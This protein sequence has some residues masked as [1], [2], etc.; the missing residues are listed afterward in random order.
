MRCSIRAR[1]S[2]GLCFS[3]APGMAFG[4]TSSVAGRGLLC[5]LPDVCVADA[6]VVDRSLHSHSRARDVRKLPTFE[7]IMRAAIRT[8]LTMFALV[9]GALM[10]DSAAAQEVELL[11]GVH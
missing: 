10:P 7:D 1:S 6:C 2:S 9:G 3:W 11:G 5:G 4:G 8:A